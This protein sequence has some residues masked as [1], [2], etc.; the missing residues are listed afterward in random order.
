MVPF[1]KLW[2]NINVN[3]PSNGFQ[4]VS[5]YV[6]I[7]FSFLATIVTLFAYNKSMKIKGINDFLKSLEANTR[8]GVSYAKIKKDS[9]FI[10][11]DIQN[12]GKRRADKISL[13]F[14]L[15]SKLSVYEDFTNSSLSLA[16]M[17]A[18]RF[19]EK[20]PRIGNYHGQLFKVSNDEFSEFYVVLKVK[21]VDDITKT[22]DSTYSYQTAH[23][24]I[25]DSIN[26]RISSK[27]EVKDLKNRLKDFYSND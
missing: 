13:E 15:F 12:Y 22:I 20:V 18:I 6:T 8:A 25:N 19:E 26:F 4:K 16:P 14:F 7:I 23:Q 2:K 24:S 11:G 21:Y 9:I 17:D 27:N 1:L 3:P 5:I 10:S